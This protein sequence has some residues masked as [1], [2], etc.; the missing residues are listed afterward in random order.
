MYWARIQMGHQTRQRT[1]KTGC[2]LGD[3]VKRKYGILEIWVVVVLP[4]LRELATNFLLPKKNHCQDF[5]D[6]FC[7]PRNHRVS[8]NF[9]TLLA[10][11][12]ARNVTVAGKKSK[13]HHD[14]LITRK[15]LIIGCTFKGAYGNIAFWEGFSE[16]SGQGSGEGSQKGSEKGVCYGFY[17]KKGFW[18]GFSEGVLR[19]GFPEGAWNAPLVEYASLTVH[20]KVLISQYPVN[21]GGLR[22]TP[23]TQGRPSKTPWNKGSRTRCPPKF[24]NGSSLP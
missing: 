10:G 18:E 19:R 7:C 3:P 22:F 14:I 2:Y 1:R 21:V 4:F 20:P 9:N 23:W 17:S 11:N 15:V 12:R 5:F 24:R 8:T 6:L 16:G 13:Q